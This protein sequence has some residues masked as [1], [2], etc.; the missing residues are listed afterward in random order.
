MSRISIRVVRPGTGSKLSIK[1]A[2]E[3]FPLDFNCLIDK[4]I[5]SREGATVFIQ[6]E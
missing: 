3:L 2:N 1:V 5:S 6:P 4:M